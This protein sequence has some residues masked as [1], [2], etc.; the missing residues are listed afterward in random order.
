MWLFLIKKCLFVIISVNH[1]HSTVIG[2]MRVGRKVCKFILFFP[3]LS[4]E[5][6]YRGGWNEEIVSA[7]RGFG[8]DSVK[9]SFSVKESNSNRNR[10]KTAWINN[11]TSCASSIRLFYLLIKITDSLISVYLSLCWLSFM[12]GLSSSELDNCTNI[13]TCLNNFEDRI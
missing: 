6:L 3:S 5:W 1:Y 11:S 10:N 9:I 8:C 7:I 12:V 4:G 13:V 2:Y